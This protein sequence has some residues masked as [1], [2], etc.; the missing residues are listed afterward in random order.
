MKEIIESGH[1]FNL[2]EMLC[3]VNKKFLFSVW[4]LYG[5]QCTID[6][7]RNTIEKY[8]SKYWTFPTSRFLIAYTLHSSEYLETWVYAILLLKHLKENVKYNDVAFGH[9]SIKTKFS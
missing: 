9:I 2:L 6:V 8:L 4:N 5:I 7:C 1:E 3:C